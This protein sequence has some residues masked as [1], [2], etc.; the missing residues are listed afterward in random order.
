MIASDTVLHVLDFEKSIDN[1]HTATKNNIQCSYVQIKVH[2]S[3]LLLGA[4]F[5]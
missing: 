3:I 1:K 5:G 2:F 4:P